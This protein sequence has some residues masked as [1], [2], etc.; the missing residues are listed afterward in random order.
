MQQ[1]FPEH[2]LRQKS[3][4]QGF[5]NQYLAG[6]FQGFYPL[7]T[8]AE[9]HLGETLEVHLHRAPTKAV[10][11]DRLLHNQRDI[12]RK[13]WCRRAVGTRRTVGLRNE[14]FGFSRSKDDSFQGI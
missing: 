1:W 8:R 2:L 10:L 14:T 13:K 7:Q 12:Q 5:R 6:L 3:Q 11:D 9:V 4:A